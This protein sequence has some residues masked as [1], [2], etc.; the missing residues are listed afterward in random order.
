MIDE[1]RPVTAPQSPSTTDRPAP[2]AAPHAPG[3][4][5]IA[6]LVA[7]ASL[8]NALINFVIGLVLFGGALVPW[9]GAWSL[10]V[11]LAL[12]VTIVGVLSAAAAI[13]RVR[14][15]A[16][17]GLV[18]G[19]AADSAWAIWP[20]G[21]WA[22]AVCAGLV[23][24][25]PVLLLV[26]ALEALVPEGLF[27][28]AAAAFKG[29]T[30]A[31][32]GALAI[33]I[34]SRR[35]LVGAPDRTAELATVLAR[36]PV[37]VALES[38]DKGCLAC[39]DRARGISVVPTWHLVIDGDIDDALLEASLTTLARRY[40]SLGARMA[41]VDGLPDHA[42]DFR[43]VAGAPAPLERAAPGESV[44]AVMARA[45][46][47]H[48]DPFVDPL[49]VFTRVRADG[50]LHLFVQQHH[51]LADGRAMIGLLSDWAAIVRHLHPASRAPLP[52]PSDAPPASPTTHD[53]KAGG[54]SAVSAA[55]L[56]PPPPA[57]GSTE[58]SGRLR[59][60]GRHLPFP[61]DEVIARRPE[62]DALGLAPAELTRL[63]RRGFW[64]FVREDLAAKLRPLPPMPWNRGRDYTGD[65]RVVRALIPMAR[66]EALRAW[67]ERVGVST[68]ALL[69]G[70]YLRAIHTF[71]SA[72]GVRADRLVAEVIVETR[73]RD[74]GFVS[75]ANHLSAWLAEVRGPTLA[76]LEAT[77]RAVHAAT[78]RESKAQ[79]HLE[80]ALF[81]AWGVAKVP[82]DALRHLVLD[83]AQVRAQ[84]GFSN[85]V[86]L[87]IPE[88]AGP[89]FRVSDVWI[90]TPAAPPHGIAL[91]ATS[92]GGRVAFNFNYKASVI[93]RSEVEALARA[94][95]AELDALTPDGVG[96]ELSAAP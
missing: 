66:I 42:R 49:I 6:R 7:G 79:A 25:L 15:G 90:T 34:A 92:Y 72:R 82:I 52:F 9:Q 16:E 2:S 26:P 8:V 20:A 54:T 51:A 75:F 62:V 48:L 69:T 38:L 61:D 80:R 78:A 27:G 29:T 77:A 33:V 65:N 14:R 18:A 84:V 73:P 46:A 60:S 23:A 30:C 43:W 1:K 36:P 83:V 81:R 19:I 63:R 93:D 53:G 24:M 21:R 74:G 5:F 4:G 85:L 59:S 39:T 41:P 70:A 57:S 11:D 3:R 91:T 32:G 31:A 71:A 96:A 87:P 47:R 64:R 12:G 58:P 35:A 68:N 95:V 13:P 89:G 10:G 76:S 94:F 17:A 40:P 22:L 86:A 56:R 88:L 67:R 50:R 44:D 28:V 55:S 37:G 45:F